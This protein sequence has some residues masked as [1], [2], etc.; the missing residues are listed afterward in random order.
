MKN[1]LI[2][3][4][5]T[6]QA[7]GLRPDQQLSNIYKLYRASRVGPE[8]DID[9]SRQVAF[10]DPGLGT[11]PDLGGR[12]LFIVQFLRKV[13][14]LALGMGLSQNVIDCYTAILK[15]YEPGDRIFLFGFSRG[16][17]TIRCVASVLNLCGVPTRVGDAPGYA[18]TRTALRRIAREA[19]HKVYEHGAGKR[20]A[21]FEAQREELARRF[22]ETY[23]SDSEGRGNVWPYF[24]GAFDT[25][26]ALGSRGWR[27]YAL[28]GALGILIALLSIAIA[29]AITAVSSL[30]FGRTFGALFVV[31]LL[32]CV[33]LGFFSQLRY[34]SDYSGSLWSRWHLA[35]WKGQYYDGFLDPR[36]NFARHA[37]SIDEKRRAFARVKWGQKKRDVSDGSELSVDF[38]QRWFAGNHSDIG[39]SYPEDESRLSDITLQWMIEELTKLPDPPLLDRSRL[40]LFPSSAGPQHCEVES[41]RERI[42]RWMPRWIKGWSVKART[43]VLGAPVHTSVLERFRLEGVWQSGVF[44]PYRPPALRDDERFKDLYA[45]VEVNDEAGPPMVAAN[46]EALD[47][48]V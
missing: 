21:Q 1:I 5:G 36:V 16:A 42:P 7:G 34:I 6:G 2:F 15:N 46:T 44:K 31:G 26:A 48:D 43:E 19:V 17:Y 3:S 47:A 41:L 28:I 33:L 37:L 32:A 35:T 18:R 39:G 4:D 9:P 40:H 22:R 27:R 45:D 25:V 13:F 14:H 20:R 12:S 8:N 29:G 23:G 30:P 24:I 10:Y 38:V 11:D